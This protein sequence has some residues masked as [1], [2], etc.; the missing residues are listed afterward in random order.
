MNEYDKEIIVEDDNV[1][2]IV[3]YFEDHPIMLLG[4]GLSAVILSIC[5]IIDNKNNKEMK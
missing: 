5:K 3:E 1:Y 4:V 2:T